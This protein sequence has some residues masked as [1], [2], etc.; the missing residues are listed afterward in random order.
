MDLGLPWFFVRHG[1]A[2]PAPAAATPLPGASEGLCLSTAAV[3][4]APVA[5][6]WWTGVRRLPDPSG[7]C[8]CLGNTTLKLCLL[9]PI[10]RDMILCAIKK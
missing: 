1:G 6:E 7:D 3:V 2:F 4:G 8:Q 5:A 9:H 10:P